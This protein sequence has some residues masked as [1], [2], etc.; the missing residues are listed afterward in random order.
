MDGCGCVAMP[1]GSP[2]FPIYYGSNIIEMDLKFTFFCF[3][4]SEVPLHRDEKNRCQNL[5][6]VV[7]SLLSC[8]DTF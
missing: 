2:L 7:S 1:H 4:R 5:T 6:F 8:D 3:R